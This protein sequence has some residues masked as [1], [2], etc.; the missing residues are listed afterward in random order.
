M[1]QLKSL[2][3]GQ[4]LLAIVILLLV[5][6]IGWI[7]LGIFAGQQSSRISPAQKKAATPLTPQLDETILET[8]ENKRVYSDSELS[9]FPIYKVISVNRGKEKTIVPITFDESE[10]NEEGNQS[11]SLE[12]ILTE[13]EQET[14][15]DDS[16]SITPDEESENGDEQTS[17]SPTP[18]ATTEPSPTPSSAPAL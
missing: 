16:G 10:L 11:G 5:L 8:I 17:P 13:Q 2:K 3:H 4:Q 1:D 12:D 9:N 7:F 14:T 6:S 18:S 15:D